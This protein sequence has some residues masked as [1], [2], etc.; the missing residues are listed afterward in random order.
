[1]SNFTLRLRPDLP[2]VSG[3]CCGCSDSGMHNLVTVTW[4]NLESH[5]EATVGRC[6]K[7]ESVP[8]LVFCQIVEDHWEDSCVDQ[9]AQLNEVLSSID[10]SSSLVSKRDER[11][12]RLEY[13]SLSLLE[14]LLGMCADP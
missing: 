6:V 1:M 4:E 8:P 5:G 14:D 12:H 9:M 13:L 2:L 3:L 11:S 7:C 10:G